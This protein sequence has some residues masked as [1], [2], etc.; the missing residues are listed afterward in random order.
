MA[1]LTPTAP[2]SSTTPVSAS[3]PGA[4]PEPD[5]A[6]RMADAWSRW[7]TEHDL[8]IEAAAALGGAVADERA[9]GAAFRAAARTGSPA[10]VTAAARS[11]RTA[12]AARTDAA[13]LTERRGRAVTLTTAAEDLAFVLRAEVGA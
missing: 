5:Q 6:A 11:F 3:P 9:A 13:A 2:P 1:T 7:C 8:L 12:R 4:S 10:D